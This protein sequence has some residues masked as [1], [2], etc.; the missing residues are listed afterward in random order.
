MPLSFKKRESSPRP[1]RRPLSIFSKTSVILLLII[2]GFWG[3][4]ALLT[5]GNIALLV[6]AL[7]VAGLAGLI[8][9]GFRWVPLLG[10]LLCGLLLFAFV[11]QSSF[12]LYHLAHPRD[13]YGPSSNPW[14]AYLFFT[15]IVILF[16]CMILTVIF[17]VA[18]VVQNYSRSD[19]G[20]PPPW[21][22]QALTG[23]IGL[24]IGAVLLG[25]FAPIPVAA[26]AST[27]AD[28]ATIIHLGVSS[29]SE[30]QVTLSKGSKLLFIDDGTFGHNIS[31]GQWVQGQPQQE[32]FPGEPVVNQM[33]FDHTDQQMEIGPF[34]TAGTYHLYCSIHRGMMLTIVVQ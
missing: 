17:G 19:H 21:F 33:K 24:L 9:R 30:T 32:H 23:L 29:F 7:V 12:P 18:A 16:W 28:G 1:P 26:V 22:R 3:L 13:A 14:L 31:T 11:T 34:T 27:A 8:S 15:V 6:N 20:A 25:A 4:I 10:S 2:S 5:P